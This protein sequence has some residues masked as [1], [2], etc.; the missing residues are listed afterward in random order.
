MRYLCA[1]SHSPVDTAH[2]VTGL[3]ETHLVKV[4]TTATKAGFVPSGQHLPR[5]NL[6]ESGQLACAMA[7]LDHVAKASNRWM[8]VVCLIH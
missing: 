2:V 5:L 8:I 7:Q 3:V 6:R 1:G 4:H